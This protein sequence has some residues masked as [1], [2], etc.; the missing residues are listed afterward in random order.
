MFDG[1][2]N[3]GLVIGA[4]LCVVPLL[5]H[6][7]NRQ[8]HKP[9]KWAAMRFVL[10]AYRRTRRRARF[11][12]WLLLLLRMAAVCLLALAVARPFSGAR[13]PLA[14]L[15]ESRRDLVVVIDGSASTGYRR[16]V[17]TVF[18]GAV[19]RARELLLEL[20]SGRGDRARLILAGSHPRLLS[21]RSPEEALSLL[22]TLSS[23]TDEPLD[24]AAA[25]GEIARLAEEQAGETGQTSLE[26]RLLCD[27]QRRSF[28]PEL[29]PGAPRAPGAAPAAPLFVEQ[30]E[31]LAALGARVLVE[32]LGPNEAT[33]ANLGVTAVET[34]APYLGVGQP[35]EFEVRVQNWGP[36]LVTGVRVTLEVDGERR[37]SRLLEIPARGQASATFSV[38]FQRS[39]PH[40]L[41]GRV[42]ADRL[43][44]DDRR[45]QIVEVPP[46]AR[47]LLVN[48]QPQ[49]E[50]DRDEVGYLAA[51]LEPPVTDDLRGPSGSGETGAPFDVRVVERHQLGDG[52]DLADYDVIVLANVPALSQPLVER[53]EQRVAAGASLIV[54][55]GDQVIPEAY[56][57]RLFSADGSG[58]LP[59]ELGARVAVRDRRN[60]YWRIAEFDIQH[61][62][63]EFFRD[64]R[65]RP[66][67]TEVPIY[68]F[69]AAKP[70][71]LG[72]ASAPDE[73]ADTDAEPRRTPAPGG[74]RVLARLDDEAGSPLLIERSYDRGKVFLWTTTIDPAW[75]RLPESPRTLVP[76]VH[77]WLRY[78]ARPERSPRNLTVGA[79]F[80]RVVS[81]FPR[82]LSV[83]Q[84]DGSRRALPGEPTPLGPGSWRLPAVTDTE[85]VGAY[86]LEIE[87]EASVP[88]SVQIDRLEGDLDRITAP[89][90]EAL[91][92]ALTLVASD[93]SQ[94][95]TQPEDAAQRGE[96]WRLLAMACLAV[97]IGES[98]W[99]AWLGHRRRLP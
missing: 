56:N 81:S 95:P 21:W 44:I 94:D 43:T 16:E 32:D 82:S 22:G 9:M 13:S 52:I 97:L 84:P 58:L 79:P 76:L 45:V 64:E 11:E 78:A 83:A 5:I 35:A 3:P 61:P 7:L 57:Q 36:N 51:V 14:G 46:P 70:L 31:R 8:R 50:I 91:H 49:F 86:A 10:A 93:A 26:I 54:T 42:D 23:P 28:E 24:L 60:A 88:F 73:A 98:L 62:A 71:E 34:D 29:A 41:I 6:L 39:G 33:P 53:L 37:P 20:D 1:F 55:V 40:V 27:L 19:D 85:R 87:G 65:W 72:D 17:S 18:E 80:V 89:E 99:A 67:L 59:A 77:E 47:V 69:L 63:F 92:P 38:V 74:A 25:V 68:E 48:G 2:V 66:L 4:A 15:T 12:N 90:L 30:L 96:L 75:T